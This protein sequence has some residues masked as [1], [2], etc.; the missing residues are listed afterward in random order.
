ME[1]KDIWFIIAAVAPVVIALWLFCGFTQGFAV[2]TLVVVLD[3]VAT[4]IICGWIALVVYLFDK[5]K[6]E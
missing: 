3:L 1:K 2:S 4:S 5:R 6:K